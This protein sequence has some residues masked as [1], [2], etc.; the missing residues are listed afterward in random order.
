MKIDGEVSGEENRFKAAL[1][2]Y[3]VAFAT[4]AYYQIMKECKIFSC[5]YAK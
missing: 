4:P 3:L 5:S 1:Q 2:P